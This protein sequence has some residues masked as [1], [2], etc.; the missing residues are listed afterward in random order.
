MEGPKIL[1]LD[2]DDTL[3]NSKKEILP[4]VRDAIGRAVAA[5]HKIVISTGRPVPGA[6]V[7]IDQLGLTAEGCYAICYNGGLI[8]DSYAKKPI[9]S[10]PLSLEEVGYILEKAR[11]AGLHAQTYDS[12]YVISAVDN[13]EIRYYS[14]K[15]HV[16]MKVDPDIP[17]S[18]TELPVKVLMIDFEGPDR[19]RKF[20]DSI[21]AWAEGRVSSFF[22]SDNYLEFV[23]EGI[24][25]GASVRIL[26]DLLGIPMENT[27]AAGDSENDIPMIVEAAVGCAMANATPAVK[28][29]ADY[30]TERDCDHAGIG[31][32][33]DRFLFN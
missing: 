30:I 2:I 3:L 21:S 18:L 25:K 23:R 9:Y 22:S 8:W 10:K 33:I 15:T 17:E 27:I 28:A 19:L 4:E 20:R 14:K 26:A 7:Y 13:E 6:L 16:P 31:E 5:G 32:I 1:F 24:S 29:A 11:E 12:E